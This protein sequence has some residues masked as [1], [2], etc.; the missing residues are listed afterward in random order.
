MTRDERQRLFD[1]RVALRDALERHFWEVSTP[2]GRNQL[3]FDEVALRQANGERGAYKEVGRTYNISPKT[4]Q[5]I[6][7]DIRRSLPVAKRA[8]KKSIPK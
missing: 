5:N 4:V 2:G 3:I 8:R 1:E 6:C 7:G